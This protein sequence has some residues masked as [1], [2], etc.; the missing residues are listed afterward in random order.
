MAFNFPDFPI[1]R[2]VSILRCERRFGT[3][4]HLRMPLSSKYIFLLVWLLLITAA[5][6]QPTLLEISANEL[7][8]RSA[9]RMRDSGGFQFA[10][11]R[12]G[13]PAFLDP[14]ETISF[15][16]AI[17]AYVAPD[18][19][20]ATVRVIGPGII[21]DIDVISVAEIQWQTNVVTNVWEE[22][23]PNWGFNPAVLFDDEI[24]IQAVLLAD[25]TEVQLAEPENLAESEVPDELLY[26]VTAVADGDN[27]YQMSGFLIGPEQVT[28]QLWIMPETF[29][30]VRIVLH[31]P[32]PNSE[33]GESIWQVD[34]SHY[35]EL[36]DIQPPEID[37]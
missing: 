8:Q 19:A 10:I 3:D 35:D 24:G 36:I 15:R 27:V 17:G 7:V 18:R 37:N 20:L 14:Q 12:D 1:K 26:S 29:E 13:A 5:C 4:R 25:L 9:E 2:G 23:P 21:T 32:E 16:R 30:L 11:E 31:E 28:L 33:D 6:R 22:L 34:I